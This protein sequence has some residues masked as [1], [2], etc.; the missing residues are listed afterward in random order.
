MRRECER[1]K[2]VVEVVFC[3]ASVCGAAPPVVEVSV[4]SGRCVPLS[5]VS[6][7]SFGC[8]Q[9]HFKFGRPPELVAPA[10]RPSAGR[11]GGN[12]K[13]STLL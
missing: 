11:A 4:S 8:L 2:R 5:L 1:W 13:F 6:S 9:A 7:F 10:P 3:G 12:K